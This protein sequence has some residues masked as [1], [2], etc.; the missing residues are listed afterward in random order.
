MKYLQSMICIFKFV[1]M[2]TACFMIGFWIF[3]FQKDE[4][5]TFIDYKTFK[6]AKETLY[7][8]LTICILRPFLKQ[9]IDNA[10]LGVNEE[11]Y[12]QYLIG[13]VQGNETYKEISYEEVTINLFDFLG[14]IDIEL[15]SKSL[16]DP[17]I[18]CINIH[19]CLYL[20]FK[21][22]FNGFMGEFGKCFGIGINR[23]YYD[24]DVSDFQLHFDQSLEDILDQGL[25][26][27][28]SLNYPNQVFQNNLYTFPIWRTSMRHNTTDKI[29]INS[30]EVLQRRNK[31]QKKCVTSWKTYDEFIIL[32][33][34]EK[35]GCR[36]P[37][38]L[39]H[40]EFPICEKPEDIERFLTLHIRLSDDQTSP[41][42]HEI[43][44]MTFTNEKKPVEEQE[45]ENT[46]S[47]SLTYPPNIKLIMQEQAIDFH[48]LIGN[49]GGYI[50]LFL[51][52]L[53]LNFS[54]IDNSAFFCGF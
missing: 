33:E 11:T 40:E 22:N 39:S 25:Y 10:S 37:Y 6:D 46:F 24:D 54:H 52:I 15:K 34:I 49:I 12:L 41:A 18:K 20:Y 3:K 13:A 50:G 43:A 9:K 35:I 48:V 21:N 38:Q 44:H 53:N 17:S 5:V 42:C 8:E 31:R 27:F 4:D 26:I 19:D 2:I 23:T 36:P 14:P 16:K 28:A 47:I 29:S 32:K 45:E 51:G 1:C 30:L 7:P